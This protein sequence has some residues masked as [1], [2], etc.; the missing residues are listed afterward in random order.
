MTTA[1]KCTLLKACVTLELC[2]GCECTWE[3]NKFLSVSLTTHVINQLQGFNT[4][5]IV[6]WF[7]HSK[8]NN[9][10]G[11][12]KLWGNEF[13]FLIVSSSNL[14]FQCWSDLPFPVISLLSDPLW[15]VKFASAKSHGKWSFSW[16]A[17]EGLVSPLTS[18][19]YRKSKKSASAV[20]PDVRQYEMNCLSQCKNIRTVFV[21]WIK[22]CLVRSPKLG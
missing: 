9:L 13:H 16:F 8:Q 6:P 18:A 4:A 19:L 10:I 2:K 5:K 21:N 7:V 11:W 1:D 3:P 22:E 14:F 17:H 12:Y 15:N 20:T